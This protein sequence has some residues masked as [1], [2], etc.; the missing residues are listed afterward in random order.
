MNTVEKILAAHSG[1]REVHPGSIVDVALDFI[2]ANDATAC[3]AIDIFKNELKAKQVFDPAK[4]IL[5]MDHY[6][7]SSSIAA[8]DSHNKMR[9]FAREQGL[10]HVYD[11]KG[12]CH[13]LMME[14]HVR[15][16]QLIIGA[17][18]HTCTYGALGTLATGMGSTD[19]AVAW[20]EGRI[21]MKVPES[22]KI[23]VKGDWPVGVNAKDLI[24]RI[25]GDLSAQGA[26]YR[27][28]YFGGPAIQALGISDRM[29]LCNMAIEAG[30]KFGYIQP[31][32]KTAAFMKRMDRAEYTCFSDDHD[33][34]YE[35]LIEYDVSQLVPQIAYPHSVDNVQ[36]ISSFEGMAV[37]E[38]F[39]GAC[40]NGRYEDLEIAARIL[41]GRKIAQGV[42]LLI[43]PASQ[44]VYL[45]AIESGLIATFIESGAM[46]TNPGCSACFG[47]SG[48]IIGKGERLLTTANRNFKGRVGSPESEIYLASP[49]VVA[50]SALNGCITDPRRIIK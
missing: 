25:I 5:V 49:A 41:K 6:T 31:D 33:A 50:A 3:L 9:A 29:T 32:Q 21:W 2:M 27:A 4:V 16:G 40:T 10:S 44:N 46:V 42:R 47:G 36:E 19:V 14:N 20:S 38:L 11:G 48:G 34:K 12:V 23:E 22:I 24:L 43:T 17:D 15:P 7:P 45:Q 13:Q 30:A 35:R 8:A 26:T 37:D 1:Q 18:S 28:L 39:L